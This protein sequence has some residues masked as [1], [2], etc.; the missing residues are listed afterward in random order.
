MIYN[1]RFQSGLLWGR[2]VN[3]PGSFPLKAVVN[4]RD[5]P[6][7]DFRPK[8]GSLFGEV[9]G[10]WRQ[11]WFMNVCSLQFLRLQLRVL[12]F[13]DPFRWFTYETWWFSTSQTVSL[14]EDASSLSCIGLAEEQGPRW[15]QRRLWR[16]QWKTRSFS[17][18]WFGTSILFSHIFGF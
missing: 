14:P 13:D 7:V 10:P 4:P 5:P 1:G 15:I 3:L 8:W 18:W 9:A 16:I 2:L 17:G 12:D 11:L 6:T